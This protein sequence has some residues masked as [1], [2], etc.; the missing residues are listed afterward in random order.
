MLFDN[1]RNALLI[2][3]TIICLFFLPLPASTIWWRELFNSGHTILFTLI[4]IVFYCR[5]N[6][7]K[8]FPRPIII[9]SIILAIGFIAGAAIE[10]LQGMLQR[11]ASVVDLSKNLL[12]IMAGLALVSSVRQKRRYKRIL[13]IAAS[14]GFIVTGM[15]SF[16]EISWH[17]AQRSKSFPM[18]IAFDKGWSKSFMQF[19]NSEILMDANVESKDGL[20][21]HRVR[22]D[23]GKYAGV[24]IIEPESDWLKYRVLRLSVYSAND[25]NI[26]LSLRIYDKQH[27]KSYDDRFNQRYIIQ[28]GLNHIVVNVSQIQS[29]PLSRNMDLTNIA[30]VKLFLSN[31]S[32]PLFLD[33]SNIFLDM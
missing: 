19:D 16:I 30:N 20:K 27:N 32:T 31:V 4:S 21:L 9:Y 25:E 7:I 10:V 1:S 22:F 6:A 26:K 14:L 18:L 29:A 13:L 5:L 11:E 15:Y 2:L 24:S 28:P 3:I 12:G 8:R 33:I 23:T 17:Y